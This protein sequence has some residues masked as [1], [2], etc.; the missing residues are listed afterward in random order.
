MNHETITRVRRD[1]KFVEVEWSKV[2]VG[3]I[4]CVNN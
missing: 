3:D 1:S 4:C 2:V